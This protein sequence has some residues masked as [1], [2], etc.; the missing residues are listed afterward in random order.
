MRDA[1]Q[2]RGLAKPVALTE[3]RFRGV[4]A[5]TRGADLAAR[6]DLEEQSQAKLHDA[7][8]VLAAHAAEHGRIRIGDQ[9]AGVS[10][11]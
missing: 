6:W 10:R 8:A 4:A 1:S 5:P 7:I 11:G 2:S 3:P 9:A